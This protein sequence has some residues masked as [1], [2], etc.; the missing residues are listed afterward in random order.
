MFG[1]LFKLVDNLTSESSKEYLTSE[2]SISNVIAS[3]NVTINWSPVFLI[4]AP[5]P[6]KSLRSSSS[7][8]SSSFPIAAPN[9]A[10]A[11]ALF[12]VPLLSSP[13]R[14]P[15]ITPAVAPIIAPCF[16]L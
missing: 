13:V 2:L 8:I 9:A 5:L 3:G 14:K 7:W 1:Y 10:P 4:S 6:S 12:I 11:I 15:D 16:A